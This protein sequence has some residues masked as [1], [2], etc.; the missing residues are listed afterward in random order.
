MTIA[1]VVI[2]LLLI[3]NILWFQLINRKINR[4]HNWIVEGKYIKK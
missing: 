3:L 2:V 4:I 1:E